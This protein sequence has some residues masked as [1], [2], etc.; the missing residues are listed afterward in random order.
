MSYQADYKRV[1]AAVMEVFE[2]YGIKTLPVSPR[3]I[4]S[5]INRH[6][7]YRMRLCP[8]SR[9]IVGTDCTVE[10]FQEYLGSDLGAYIRK[11]NRIIIYYNDTLDNQGL[12]RFTIAHELGHHFL[13]HSRLLSRDT[14][15]RGMSDTEYC[16]IEKEANCFARNLL[17]P[18]Y[19]MNSIGIAPEDTG[20]ISAIFGLSHQAAYI[21]YL[22]FRADL[23]Q[24]SP[25]GERLM[26]ERFHDVLG[27]YRK[28]VQEPQTMVCSNCNTPVREQGAAYCSICGSDTFTSYRGGALLRYGVIETDGEG[29]ALLC[30]VCGNHHLS[31]FYCNLC[32]SPIVNACC[33][34]I[35]K[36]PFRPHSGALCD[37]VLP[38]NARYCHHC[39]RESVFFQ[40]GYLEEWNKKQK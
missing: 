31:G 34:N 36:Y 24:C 4:I 1:Y 39:G 29:R 27:M 10:E 37:T 23:A 38:G 9:A 22:H 7:L 19:L 16:E 13:N 8:Y 30:P 33:G 2:T 32:G 21:R 28:I 14:L 26:R 5:Q 20:K 11:D 15:L 25:F 18:V 3:Q 17:A 12:D 35:G 6:S 40:E